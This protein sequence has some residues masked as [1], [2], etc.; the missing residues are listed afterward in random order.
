MTI[1]IETF[2]YNR[3]QRVYAS[4]IHPYT[5][6][7]RNANATNMYAVLCKKLLTKSGEIL[8]KPK[9]WAQSVTCEFSLRANILQRKREPTCDKKQQHFFQRF[10]LIFKHITILNFALFWYFIGANVVSVLSVVIVYPF[11]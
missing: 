10:P 5:V 4:Y 7:S 6:T 8:C 2:V 11:G 9:T 3:K 1:S